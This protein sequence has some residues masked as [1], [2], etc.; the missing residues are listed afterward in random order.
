[1]KHHEVSSV[2]TTD[3]VTVTYGTPFKEVARL[4]ARH[5][6]S[7]LPVVDDDQ[8]VIGVISE[9]DLMLRQADTP[10]PLRPA[11]RFRWAALTRGARRQAAKARARTAG[12]LIPPVPGVRKV[13]ERLDAREH[14]TFGGCL[15]EGAKGRVAGMILR[16]GKGG[17]FR[18]FAVIEEWAAGIG[19]ALTGAA[20]GR[21]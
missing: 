18:D 9:T 19:S 1:M 14:V 2:M 17:D 10:D 8:K 16:S 7:G 11:R 5:R 3:V 20:R 21:S 15:E 13:V 6:I 12:L 4:L